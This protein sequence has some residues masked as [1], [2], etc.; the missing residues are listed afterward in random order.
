MATPKPTTKIK[1]MIAVVSGKGGVG[2]SMVTDLLAVGT[3]RRGS[4]VA[5]LDA[6]ITP[7]E[8]LSTIAVSPALR[9]LGI[10]TP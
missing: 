3:L 10:I 9:R 8:D 4:K 5:V 7:A 6:D 2:K 1:K